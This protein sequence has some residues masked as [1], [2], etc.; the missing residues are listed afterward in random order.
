MDP[1]S[2]TRTCVRR[3]R[4]S[5]AESSRAHPSAAPDPLRQRAAAARVARAAGLVPNITIM[6]S[7]RSH[8]HSDGSRTAPA[9]QHNRDSRLPGT[10]RVSQ[11]A[12]PVGRV[13]ADGTASSCAPGGAPGAGKTPET[14]RRSIPTAPGGLQ[15][16]RSTAGLEPERRAPTPGSSPAT[17]GNV[18]IEQVNLVVAGDALPVRVVHQRSAARAVAAGA[19]AAPCRPIH[20][21]RRR[22]LA[23][24]KSCAGPLPS[25]SATRACR[26]PSIP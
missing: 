13:N 14:S 9:P 10:R 22:A 19:P 4:C 6:L 17:P 12:R 23:A 7:R 26:R 11:C 3:A 16:C 5:S 1:H 8:V 2:R 25:A 18:D 20:S 21:R 15:A 24:R